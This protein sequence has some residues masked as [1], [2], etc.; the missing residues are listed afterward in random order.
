MS[1]QTLN[2]KTLVLKIAVDKYEYMTVEDDTK[3]VYQKK[4][5]KSTGE[6]QAV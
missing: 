3:S 1:I 5:K 2:E 6:R 4:K